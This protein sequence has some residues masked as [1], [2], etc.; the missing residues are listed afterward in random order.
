MGTLRSLKPTA[1]RAPL[2]VR[3]QA[4]I[5]AGAGVERGVEVGIT[6]DCRNW[7]A[8]RGRSVEA[9]SASCV[10][11]VVF[12][13]IRQLEK[14]GSE[15]SCLLGPHLDRIAMRY[16][17]DFHMDRATIR[18]NPTRDALFVTPSLRCLIGWHVSVLSAER[19][20]CADRRG[21]GE[22]GN[23]MARSSRKAP[24]TGQLRR[25]QRLVGPWLV[26]LIHRLRVTCGS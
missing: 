5:P 15:L 14:F 4:T 10:S 24:T 16:G 12:Q 21:G 20:S 22:R 25:Y 19:L 1:S 23:G 26:N 9:C 17:N 2:K 11:L 8:G 3:A 6:G 18:R 7:A 13:F